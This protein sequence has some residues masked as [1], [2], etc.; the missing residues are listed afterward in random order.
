MGISICGDVVMRQ[1]SIFCSYVVPG[2]VRRARLTTPCQSAFKCFGIWNFKLMF[3]YIEV[4]LLAHHIQ[5][6]K[7]HGQTVKV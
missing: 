7:T 4:L 3:Y 1:H 5:R 6:I 2:V